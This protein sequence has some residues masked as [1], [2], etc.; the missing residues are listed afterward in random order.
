MSLTAPKVQHGSLRGLRTTLGPVAVVHRY[1]L[2]ATV[3]SKPPSRFHNSLVFRTSRRY[4]YNWFPGA[5]Y[6]GGLSS[7]AD[8]RYY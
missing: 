4:P 1:D 3:D 5:F 7:T 6:P 8:R 2:L